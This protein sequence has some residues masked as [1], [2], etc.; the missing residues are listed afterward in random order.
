[1]ATDGQLRIWVLL[2][3]KAGDNA[4]ALTLAHR[5][6]GHVETK[7]LQFNSLHKLPNAF[8]G[9]S[10]AA[11]S[12]ITRAQLSAPWPQMVIGVGKRSAPVALWIKAQSGGFTKAVQLGRPRVPLGL[13]D[14]VITSSQYGLPARHNVVR[15]DRPFAT[16]APVE[17]AVIERWAKTWANLPR[18][19]LVAAIGA[20]K[21]PQ[22]LGRDELL[23]FGEH[24]HTLAH[25]TRSSV[26][27]FGSPR[28]MT[29]ATEIVGERIKA[30]LWI[31]NKA[32]NTDR[33]YSV[34]IKLG[35]RF[36]VTS[37]SVS[38]IT[39]MADTG[40]PCHVMVLPVAKTRFSWG[41][42]AGVGRW[43]VE[44]GLFHP[45]R[46]TQVFVDQLIGSGVLTAFNGE[47]SVETGASGSGPSVS[48]DTAVRLVKAL[49][50]K[51]T[52]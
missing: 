52:A 51:Q 20:Q 26:L 7:Q 47:R 17:D 11:L 38:M 5:L 12:P 23:R 44:R 36:A 37:D 41:A 3:A 31:A 46:N 8:L 50:D 35:D 33:A 48:R 18:P 39:E 16:P 1:M 28:S 43:L 42:E 24:V 40:K 13:F 9:A 6:G 45:P 14:L 25:E 34:A 19:W 32:A 27:L 29:R 22:Y 49:V 2:G 4:Q 15:I 10:V 30:P 21:H